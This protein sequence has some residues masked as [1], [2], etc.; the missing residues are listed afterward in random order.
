MQGQGATAEGTQPLTGPPFSGPPRPSPSRPALAIGDLGQPHQDAGEVDDSEEV[1]PSLFVAG[2]DCSEA[3]EPM[4]ETLNLI[5]KAVQRAILSPPVVLARRVHRDDRVH[6]SRLRGEDDAVCVVAGVSNEGLARC[7]LNEVLRLGCV[8]LVSGR[9]RDL[10]RLSFR[11]RDGVDFRRKASSRTAQTIASDPPFPPAASWW[12][13]TTVASMREPMSS[14][15]IWS[16]LKMRSQSPRA[17]QRAKRL[18]T[19]FHGPYRS[20]RSLQGTPVLTRQS[21]ALMKL[22][23]P[24]LPRGPGRR[25]RSGWMSCHCE[26]VSSCRCTAS[27]DQTLVR[28]ATMI[29]QPQSE[30]H[31]QAPAPLPDLEIG[32]TP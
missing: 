18:Y 23:S 7:V 29:C 15:S 22:R 13:R 28:R 1:G 8:V 2:S 24:S 17:A 5:A 6:S 16:S 11:R 20:W 3:F 31:F 19:V 12:A 27:V 25:G 10:K 26:S 14:I 32:D 9:Q 4:K 30:P 21:T